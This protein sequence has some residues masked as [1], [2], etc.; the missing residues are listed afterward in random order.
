MQAFL[1]RR[2]LEDCASALR[3]FDGFALFE[4]TP[5][6]VAR[7]TGLDGDQQLRLFAALAPLKLAPQKLRGTAQSKPL[8]PRP[9]PWSRH[10]PEPRIWQTGA[11]S[12][13]PSANEV[14]LRPYQLP[15][16]TRSGGRAG[17]AA[18]RKQSPRRYGVSRGPSADG[19]LLS[20]GERRAASL[21]AAAHRLS[22]PPT[23]GWVVRQPGQGP[24][25]HMPG[26]VGGLNSLRGELCVK[27]GGLGE[28]MDREEHVE[29]IVM[30]SLG[31]HTARSAPL[32][33]VDSALLLADDWQTFNFRVEPSL[34]SLGTLALEVVGWAPAAGERSLGRVGIPVREACLAGH[35]DLDAPLG[36]AVE[37]RWQ[38][39][40]DCN[41]G[42][43]WD[44]GSAWARA[45][46]DAWGSADTITAAAVEVEQAEAQAEVDR[47][48]RRLPWAGGTNQQWHH[49]G[50]P[51]GDDRGEENG[52]R[53]RESWAGDKPR[54]S[55]AGDRPPRESWAG[56][57]G[58]RP[59]GSWAGHARGGRA[60][61]GS[62]AD[63][64]LPRHPTIQYA[65]DHPPAFR[66]SN[67]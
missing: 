63:E 57:A 45:G 16:R 3:G 14:E 52:D 44:A 28:A 7:E 58:D 32:P 66:F 51:E 59:R 6:D 26:P 60:G 18:S 1:V 37:V 21:S 64:G 24:A 11:R 38:P 34:A 5:R 46:G 39:D 25:P 47:L 4:L 65:I 13:T 54:E 61:G 2:G 55:R 35:V 62:L 20:D 67:N 56:N 10:E 41:G 49:A 50:G 19:Y 42:G 8:P 36:V 53:P 43:A 17:G 12:A 31:P 40:H 23:N 9:P 48:R 27:I 30:L 29:A 15:E 22:R 33:R